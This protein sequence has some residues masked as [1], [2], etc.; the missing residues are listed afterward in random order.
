MA[1]ALAGEYIAG[2][3]K[4]FRLAVSA[5]SHEILCATH[6][7][8]PATALVSLAHATRVAIEERKAAAHGS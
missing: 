5:L 2:L 6:K 3:E 8:G 1:A 4:G 7:I